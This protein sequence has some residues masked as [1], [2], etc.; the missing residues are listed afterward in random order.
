[1]RGAAGAVSGALED[2]GIND[3]TITQI[4]QTLQPGISALFVLV[5]QAT[6]DR[7]AEA[8]RAYNPTIIRTS[9]SY[10]SEAQLAQALAGQVRNS[11][12][13]TAAGAQSAQTFTPA[14]A[15]SR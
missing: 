3:D 4:G 13:L 11:E 2:I 12:T 15:Q 10:D 6:F 14:S 8:L 9:L 1:M 5:R 7:V